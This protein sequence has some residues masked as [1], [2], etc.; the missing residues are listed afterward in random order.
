MGS[1]ARRFAFSLVPIAI[2]YNVAHYLS[3]LLIQ[4]Q[5]LIPLASD[6]L[7]RG[8]NLLGT[9]GYRVNIAVIGA[10]FEWYA[11]V[12]VIV[13]GHIT[14]VWHAHRTAQHAIAAPR[15]AL[16]S[17]YPMTALMVAYTVTSL[18][19]LAAPVVEA[20]RPGLPLA[21][22]PS[23]RVPVPAD[24][25][26]PK[27][28]SGRLLAVGPG[29]AARLGVKFRVLG[30][31]F[32]DGTRV[33]AADL[34]YPYVIAWR[35]GS[36]RDGGVYDPAIARATALARASLLGLRVEASDTVS[37]SIRFGDVTVSH[38]L[39]LIDA[40]FD[41]ATGD[42]DRL[43]AV[44]PPWNA[45][46][47]TVLALMEETVRRGWAAF[48]Q[49]EAARRGVPW[50]DL[51]R[52]P[53][54]GQ[55]MAGLIDA[56]TRDGFRPVGLESL[57]TV[58]EARQRWAALA[59]FY[60]E[61]GH[62]LVTNGPYRLKGWSP[63]AATLEA[64]RDLSYPLGVGSFD[65]LPTPRRAFITKVEPEPAGLQ[66]VVEVERVQKFQR[67]YRIVRGPLAGA[68]AV[69]GPA[70]PPPV[71]RYLVLG[72]DSE[73]VLAGEGRLEAGSFHLDLTGRLAPGD[74]SVE[75]AVYVGGNA[76]NPEIARIP[77][78]VGP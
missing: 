1:L 21:E 59:A 51:V 75:A 2:A 9:A 30:S 61:H 35:W 31:A 14:A 24:A 66:L 50:L 62:F 38:E 45:A 63:G 76:M 33:T 5:Y 77:Y 40:Y 70:E 28:G 49:E 53:E 15:Q 39:L 18:S 67:S 6:P 10:R 44:A 73:V 17:Q 78:R 74:Y 42:L 20:G 71:C 26:L 58:E 56:F 23:D 65:A 3:F 43:A 72:R 29:K 46:P 11:A 8:W 69:I 52:S 13:L 7:G 60:R 55:R 34:F 36:E 41:L 54:L 27:P 4:G 68:P 37:R 25:V 32:H 19:I 22:T 12:S 16:A 57:V 64:F 47:W 48:S